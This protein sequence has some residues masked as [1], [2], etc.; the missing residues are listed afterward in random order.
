MLQPFSDQSVFIFFRISKHADIVGSSSVFHDRLRTAAVAERINHTLLAIF[1]PIFLRHSLAI[2]G[3]VNQIAVFVQ[4]AFLV[5]RLKISCRAFV[6]G[7]VVI[8]QNLIVKIGVTSSADV[9]RG[10]IGDKALLLQPVYYLHLVFRQ[11]MM[12][13]VLPDLLESEG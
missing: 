10:Q 6:E 9:F 1:V 4:Q 7:T 12:L 8:D 11:G 5:V 2:D 13:L 3:V